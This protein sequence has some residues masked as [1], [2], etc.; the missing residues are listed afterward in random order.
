MAKYMSK[1][2]ETLAEAQED[3]GA[4]VCPSTWWNMSKTARD[5]VKSRTFKGRQVG[6]LLDTFMQYVWDTGD[7]TP[8]EFVRPIEIDMDGTLVV[9]GWRGRFTPVVAENLR[10]LVECV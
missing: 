2:S 3:W 6:E 9:M 5:W 4:D 8:V 1:G 10:Q 7:S